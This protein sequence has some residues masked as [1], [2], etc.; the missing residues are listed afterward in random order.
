M[1]RILPL[2]ILISCSALA[3][4][5]DAPA[6]A[7]TNS[8]ATPVEKIEGIAP[9]R[10]PLPLEEDSKYVD[11]FSFI[12]YGDTRGRRDG[13]EL[14]NEHSLIV[15]SML[16][17]IKK[18]S[19]TSF[20]VRFVLQ[21]G[22][23]VV[24]GRDAKQWNQSFVSL[25][26]RI[27]TE[28]RVPY[29]LT[30]GNHDVMAAQD[31]NNAQRK[32]GL[33]N[34]LAAVAQLIPV[35]GAQALRRL[36]GFPCYAFGYGNSF[37]IALDSNLAANKT[38]LDWVTA[39]LDGL[40][41]RRYTNVFAFFHHPPYSSG[42]H[43]GANIEAPT[44]WLRTNYMPVF[45]QY[46]VTALFTGHEH[47]FEHWVERYQDEATNK[48]RMDIIVTGGGGAPL[49]GYRGEPKLTDY[50]DASPSEKISVE[51]LV[52]PGPK[53]GDNPYHYVIVDVDGPHLTFEVIGV[54]GGAEYK[55]YQSNK[56]FV[57]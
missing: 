6:I 33:T 24:D 41:R 55:P 31:I 7:S 44:A 27:T 38:Q 32:E 40:D 36:D 34:Y 39:Q 49:Y 50:I 35:E 5:N 11:R 22:D 14:Q 57:E 28:G 18:L 37:F 3:Q 25:I 45:R 16:K 53:P 21:T 10:D 46:H 8:P 42:P 30:P 9:P 43:G 12:V 4:T 13:K 47:L 52:K 56:L 2:L 19:T 48:F 29:F 15:E 54:D 23:A 26:N 1:I 20:P 17:N 51:H